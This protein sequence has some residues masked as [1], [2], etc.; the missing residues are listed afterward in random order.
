[1]CLSVCLSVSVLL[2]TRL[3]FFGFLVFLHLLVS[4]WASP[5]MGRC[6]RHWLGVYKT[7]DVAPLSHSQARESPSI[8][9]PC[10]SSS[11]IMGYVLQDWTGQITSHQEGYE[12]LL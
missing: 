2:L 4:P 1:M 8:P 6:T 12:D 3:V 9:F 10:P 5:G 7:N 11:G